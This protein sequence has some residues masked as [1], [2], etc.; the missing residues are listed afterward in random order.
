MKEFILKNEPNFVDNK[1]FQ[2]FIK[3]KKSNNILS[4]KDYHKSFYSKDENYI[5][6]GSLNI[7]KELISVNKKIM[8]YLT[9]SII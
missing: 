9:L 3:D 7:N 2:K 8:I 1:N 6:I 4:L 5:K